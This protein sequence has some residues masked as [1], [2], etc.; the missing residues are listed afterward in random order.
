MTARLAL[1][2][3][4]A[5]LLTGATPA[6][7]EA[8]KPR[9]DYLSD[10]TERI[11]WARQS[12]GLLGFDE[13]MPLDATKPPAPLQ[14]AGKHYAKGL[15]THANS[16]I[17]VYIDGLYAT[18]E[19]DAGCPGT[20][21]GSV[22]F[23]VFGDG[24]KLYDSGLVK[25]G[26]PLRQIRVSV[27]GVQLLTL[28]VTDGG[29]LWRNDFANWGDAHLTRMKTGTPRQAMPVVEA[30]PFGRVMTS[31]PARLEGTKAQRLEEFPAADLA[32]EQEMLPEADGSWT[33][34]VH[35]GL[36]CIGMNWLER[37]RVQMLGLEFAADLPV[38]RSRGRGLKLDEYARG[39]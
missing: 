27:V 35:N 14:I 13:S 6:G 2:L 18:F 39:I 38:P 19:A 36:G 26:E 5:T 22:V 10:M 29:D 3:L 28:V 8:S 1:F 4:M 12:Y 33:V 17:F 16:E 37:H 21:G 24:K 34:P 23:Q 11:A 20:D 30:A 9:V 7:A 31:D 32:M 15:S 25:G